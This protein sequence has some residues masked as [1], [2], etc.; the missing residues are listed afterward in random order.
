MECQEASMAEISEAN[1]ENYSTNKK[2]ENIALDVAN[3]LTGD[4]RVLKESSHPTED[5][6]KGNTLIYI[7]KTQPEYY[8]Y[9]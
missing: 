3:E 2:H 9:L 8:E 7:N 6:I 1:L 5:K 4:G